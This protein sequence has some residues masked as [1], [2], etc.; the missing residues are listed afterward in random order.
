M[1]YTCSSC[2]QVHD[3]WPALVF[4]SPTSY[5]VLPDSMKE[6][7]GELSDDFCIIRHPEQTDRFIRCTLT[8][9]VIDHCEDLD[10]GLWVSLSEPSFQDYSDNFKDASHEATYFGWLSND[11]PEYEIL[12]SIPTTV[13][14][15]L[16]GQRPEIVPHEDFEHPLVHDYYHG[17]AK[18]AAERRIEAMLKMVNERNKEEKPSKPWWRLW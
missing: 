1:K 13:F 14:T 15:R 7:I 17:I 4:S 3:E 18:A 11:I 10:Y 8:L 16:N 6:Q 5:N 12:D 9:K 2:G